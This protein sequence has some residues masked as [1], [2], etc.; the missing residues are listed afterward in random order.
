MEP[1]KPRFAESELDELNNTLTKTP[2][3]TGGHSQA[4]A[5]IYNSHITISNNVVTDL[6]IQYSEVF[7][8]ERGKGASA[9]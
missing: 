6:N 1:Q 4:I 3:H 5:S 7:D 8:S 9:R 2:S